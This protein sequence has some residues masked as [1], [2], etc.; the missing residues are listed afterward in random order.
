MRQPRKERAPVTS[1]PL[2][3][4]V[5]QR[6]KECLRANDTIARLGG[7]EF[8]ILLDGIHEAGDAIR[9]AERIHRHLEAPFNLTQ[10]SG[11]EVCASTSIGI[12][13]NT[14]HYEDPA[15]LLR[16]ADTALCR[17]KEQGRARYQIFDK[18]MHTKVVARLQLENELRR[19]IER[20]E[21]VVH[22]QPIIALKSGRIA[23][24]EALARWQSPERGLVPPAGA[25]CGV[26]SRGRRKRPHRVH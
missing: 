24:F 6:L 2:L 14:A 22:Y 16:D 7:G 4:G 20:Q 25:A 13:L 3:I 18:A 12:A 15:H 8:S 23:G 26:H 5:A 9:M 21:F 17:A 11:H 10:Q 19:A 1:Q